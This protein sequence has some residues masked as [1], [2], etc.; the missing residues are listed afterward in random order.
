MTSPLLL[1]TSQ[2]GMASRTSEAIGRP[3]DRRTGTVVSFVD[4]VLSVSVGGGD[5]EDV[6]YIDSYS[7]VVG[8]VVILVLQR[9]TWVC[10]GKLVDATQPAPTPEDTPGSVVAGLRFNSFANIV[11]TDNVE[12]LLPGYSFAATVKAQNWY[13]LRAS[14]LTS[15]TTTA[16]DQAQMVLRENG[17]ALY[18]IYKPC[19]GGHVFLQTE[20]VYWFRAAA[21]GTFT[22]TLNAQRTFG[23]ATYSYGHTTGDA[24]LLISHGLSPITPV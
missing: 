13:Q 15:N 18:T 23:A 12:H 1:P 22:Y 20:M 4:R 2:A 9:S 21:D 24:F 16:A 19:L 7:P 14:F 10:L 8:D 5:P 6:G 3:P 11:W 17:V